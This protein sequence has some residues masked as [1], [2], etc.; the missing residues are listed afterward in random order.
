[1]NPSEI[2]MLMREQPRQVPA[3]PPRTY[4]QPPPSNLPYLLLGM[5]K[6]FTWLTGAS[7]VLALIY[8]RF[9]FPRVAR[10]AFARLSLKQHH[11]SLLSKLRES[12][13]VL[14]ERQT[15]TFAVL[16]KPPPAQEDRKY[17]DVHSLEDLDVSSE[18]SID[19]PEYTLL[20]CVI[21]GQIAQKKVTTK[22]EIFSVLESHYP[23]LSTENGVEYQT[24]L[25]ETLNNHPDFNEVE[26]GTQRIWTF[27]R[28]PP[29]DVEPSP[30]I[31]SMSAL[32][33][34]LPPKRSPINPYQHTLDTLTEFTGYVT[35]QTY[36][37]ST[38]S[39]RLPGISGASA[40]LDP[41]QEEVRREIRAL[42]GLVLNRRTFA[43]SP[44]A[45]ARA[46][47]Y[48]VADGANTAI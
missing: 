44:S 40:P 10:T 43:P 31:D 16:P 35:T 7:A 17:N 22:E 13:D 48:A 32:R 38:S 15:E 28:A 11:I 29:G 39:L 19:V 26:D 20:R 3:I 5:A 46:S 25:W 14:K 9:L 33:K 2:E 36:Q 21:E 18:A 30:L 41:Q 12:L 8:Y 37:M 42:K 34:S 1:M 45:A 47:L 23:W 24:S 6:L 27:K 4:P